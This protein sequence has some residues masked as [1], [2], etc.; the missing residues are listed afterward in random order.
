MDYQTAIERI[1]EYVNDGEIDRAVM[2]CLRIARHRKDYVSAAVFLR[3][4]YPEKSEAMRALQDDLQTLNKETQEFIFKQSLEQWLD[5]HS[6]DFDF[7]GDPEGDRKVFKVGV[8]EIS[9]EIEQ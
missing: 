8:G 2:A 6:L 1:Y 9:A 4:M 5:V 7:T 3:E